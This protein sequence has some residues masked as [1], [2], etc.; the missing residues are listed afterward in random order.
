M[1]NL[2]TASRI[3]AVTEDLPM[4]P[5]HRS[6]FWQG[7]NRNET[8]C[9]IGAED[10][11]A[12]IKI[13]L[14]KFNRQ[15]KT[16]RAYE[17]ELS[18]FLMWCAYCNKKP[19]S[20]MMAEDCMAYV[21]FLSNIDP[22]WVGSWAPKHSTNWKP[23]AKQLSPSSQKYALN[24]VKG[25][26]NWLLQVNYL[27][28][29]PWVAIS[30]KL[31]VSENSLNI[32]KALPLE[33][34]Y[35]LSAPGGLLDSICRANTTEI[36]SFIDPNNPL[37]SLRQYRVARAAMY[38]MGFSG[39]RRAEV[40]GSVRGSLTPVPATELWE[41]KVLGK[42]RKWR[43]VVLPGRTVDALKAH[44]ADRG[45]DFYCHSSTNFALLSPVVRTYAPLAAE[46][47]FPLDGLKIVS[48]GEAFTPDALYR[49][50][51][52]ALRALA[53]DLSLDLPLAYRSALRTAAPHAFRHT[54]GTAAAAKNMPIDVIQKLMGHASIQTSSIYIQAERKRSVA[55]AQ[56]F[57]SD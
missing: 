17:K 42:G 5:G 56:K 26:F 14:Q 8:F 48:A 6:D 49:V 39:L 50:V 41:L 57:F 21:N 7:E 53:K 28:G 51:V 20:N 37:V 10:D 38:L 15:E 9:L 54:F 19:L 13:Y 45:H 18:R 1:A 22:A 46:K 23:F 30:S 32:Q 31:D 4:A 25:C 16:L 47:H 40:C 11:L 35:L 52:K 3:D 55:E 43:T 12:A 2:L 29:N 36:E 27:K 24:V 33:L 44:W 34:W